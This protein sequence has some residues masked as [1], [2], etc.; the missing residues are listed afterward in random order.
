MIVYPLYTPIFCLPHLYKSIL[1]ASNHPL[2]LAVK[3][4]TSDVGRVAG[5][6]HDRLGVCRAH[7][8]E[9]DIVIT[10]CGEIAFVGGDTE[11]VDLRVRVLD[12]AGTDT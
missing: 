4:N 2:S 10:R 6:D 7:I 12:C 1:G 8:E 3:R 5:K 9:L 11:A